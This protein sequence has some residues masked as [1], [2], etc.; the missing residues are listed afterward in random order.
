MFR[1]SLGLPSV[2][3]PCPQPQ[4]WSQVLLLCFRAFPQTRS[5]VCTPER[6]T[7]LRFFGNM[8]PVNAHAVWST[9]E[10]NALPCCY[11]ACIKGIVA[12]VTVVFPHAFLTETQNKLFFRWNRLLLSI[13]IL[14]LAGMFPRICR[15]WLCSPREAQEISAR[16]E[17][18][19]T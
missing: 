17:L 18:S 9:P 3:S 14:L 19:L 2:L 15:V 10:E 11:F 8:A 6:G 1:V 13:S 12:V 16:F 4:L 5:V 7:T